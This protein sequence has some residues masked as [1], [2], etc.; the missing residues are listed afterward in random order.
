MRLKPYFPATDVI[1]SFRQA[2]R[3]IYMTATLSD[4]S[5][6]I[7][8]FGA[9]PNNVGQPIVPSSSQSMGERMILMP[10]ELN[11]DLAISDIKSLL[12]DLSNDVNVVVIVPSKDAAQ[13]WMEDANETLMGDAV[14]EGVE[15]LRNHHV[16]L[17]VL[18]NRYDG[19]DLPGDA[20]RVLAIYNLPE[21]SSYTDLVD[22]VVLSGTSINLRRQIERIEQGMGRGV[23][24]NDDYCVVLLLGAKLTV[25]LRSPEGLS[26]LTPATKAQLDFSRKI[27]KQLNNPNLHEIKSVI[28]QCLQR[29]P[30]WMKVSKTI[31]VNIEAGDE[32]RLDASKLAI[33][34]A[35][36]SARANQDSDAV[37]VL[38]QAI[39][40]TT[41]IQEKAWL[42]SRKA[43]FQHAIDA[44]GAQ[45]TLSVA[46]SMEQGVM[47]P[48]LSTTYK[49]L[50]PATGKQASALIN[51]HQRFF[52]DTTAMQLYSDAL[53]A[54]LKF[55]SNAPE[56]FEAALN[57]LAWFLGIQGN[58]PEKCYNEG[59]D[60]L[61]ALPNGTFLI[62]ECKNCTTSDNGISKKDAGQLGQSVAWFKARYPASAHVPIII[63][64]N[65]NLCHGA[66]LI[67][68]MKVI[69]TKCLE[70]LRER[71]KDLT[72]Q[73][74]NPDT[75]TAMTEVA[76]RLAQLELSANTIVNAFSVTVKKVPHQSP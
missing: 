11:P 47:K 21:V 32:L 60:N 39:D 73:L 14:A 63:H 61:W 58:R 38:D 64:P 26:F 66:S 72:K 8:H 51:N 27:A 57:D 76:K 45:S 36:D 22:S 69:D 6:I 4:D 35:F 29:D 7:T 54:E 62:I 30:N 12:S 33:R 65:R 43:A 23:R 41:N 42:L 31:L 34:S 37:T 3:R 17:T 75:A 49:K 18:V 71:I 24:S 13:D 15:K 68:N 19:I 25:R 46:H 44:D 67:N 40:N 50:T 2:K 53:R 70:K 10:Q 56:K 16:G 28:F 74:A 1:Q 48:M 52:I 59:P 5:V 9:D 20:C 55:H